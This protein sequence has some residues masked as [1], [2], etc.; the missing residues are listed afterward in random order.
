MLRQTPAH[1]WPTRLPR[2]VAV[3]CVLAGVL[4]TAALP[5]AALPPH[6]RDGVMVGL[7]LGYGPGRLELFPV[8]GEP[9]VRSGKESGSTP[10][11]RL[12]YAV[13]RDHLLVVLENRQWIVEQGLLAED[14]LRINTQCWTLG[15]SWY[16]GD[17]ATAA[18][19]FYVQAG[20]G[21]ANARLTLLEPAE[22]NPWGEMFHEVGK[23]DEQGAAFYAALG[24]EFRIL[25]HAAVGL[26][27]GYTYLS[28]GEDIFDTAQNWP[29]CLTLN[30]YW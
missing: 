24:Y 13:L 26:S 29:L 19:G 5:A 17:P 15:L 9:T 18:G 6:E 22:D 14:K 10:Q 27:A 12:G 7:S 23:Q 2:K 30:W 8:A 4:L 11:I 28:V 25:T 1:D 3:V 21:L 20:G 16:P